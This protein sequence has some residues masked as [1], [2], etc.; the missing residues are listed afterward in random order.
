MAKALDESDSKNELAPVADAALRTRRTPTRGF[1]PQGMDSGDHL[2]VSGASGCCR[3][4][5][6]SRRCSKRPKRRVRPNVLD[7]LLGAVRLP[8][9]QP[10][11]PF[12]VP[13]TGTTGRR[14][15]A[16][17]GKT[18]TPRASDRRAEKHASTTRRWMIRRPEILGLAE[19]AFQPGGPRQQPGGDP[20]EYPVRAGPIAP[21]L[22]TPVLPLLARFS[23]AKKA[24]D[25]NGKT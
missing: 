12:P 25:L 8:G 13:P 10:C 19:P 24:R 14:A 1:H 18:R 6:K 17:D 2:Y 22:P 3:A 20:H 16:D 21:E 15:R 5:P 11:W 7:I 23:Q 4:C 9:Q